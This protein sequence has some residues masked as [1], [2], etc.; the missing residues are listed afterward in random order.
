MSARID[1]GVILTGGR[2]VRMGEDKAALIDAEGERFVDAVAATLEP[3]CARLLSVGRVDSVRGK[4]L[5]HY[6]DRAPDRGPLMG[7]VRGLDA[8]MESAAVRWVLVASCDAPELLAEDVKALADARDGA[9]DASAVVF[10]H[11]GRFLPLPCLLSVT[12]GDVAR[13][14]LDDPERPGR[15]RS[16]M[17]LL[18]DLSESREDAVVAI[19]IDQTRALRLRGVNT[20]E[21]LAAMR[22]RRG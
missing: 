9:D 19:D 15:L 21:E 3:F 8:A 13:A 7:L 22:S 11:E 18:R 17:A 4:A 10:S 1:C 20:P 2:S 14:M 5:A 12:V 16:P 6:V